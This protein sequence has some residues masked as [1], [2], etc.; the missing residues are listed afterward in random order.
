MR[1]GGGV[2]LGYLGVTGGDFGVG[3][4]RFGVTWVYF[5]V[6]GGDLGSPR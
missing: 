2:A 4:V 5:G 6:A 1:F 3:V